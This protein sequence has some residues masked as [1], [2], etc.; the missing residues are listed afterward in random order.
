MHPFPY[1]NEVWTG[2]EYT[3]ASGMLYE[4]QTDAALKVIS[5]VRARH[6][7]LRRSPFNEPECGHHYARAMASWSTLVAY[8]GFRHDGIEKRM[9]FR[10]A[11]KP[12]TWFWSN[13]DAWGT[14][15]Q[16]PAGDGADIIIRTLGGTLNVARVALTGIGEANVDNRAQANELRLHVKR[17]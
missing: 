13:G 16:T 4:G 1:C 14:V 11:D 5:A 7:G 10:A 2:L 3:A 8:T 17:T 6:D 9:T 12:A 15:E